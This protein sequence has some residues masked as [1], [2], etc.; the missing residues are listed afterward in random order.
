MAQTMADLTKKDST[1]DLTKARRMV[2]LIEM[3]HYL[4]QRKHLEVD[5]AQQMELDWAQQRDWV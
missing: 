1:K 4:V 3:G 2:L 5:W